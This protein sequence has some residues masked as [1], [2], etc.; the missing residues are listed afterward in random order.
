MNPNDHSACRHRAS[1]KVQSSPHSFFLPAVV[2]SLLF[3]VHAGAQDTSGRTEY[4]NPNA[5]STSS[6][7]RPSASKPAAATPARTSAVA[8]PAATRVAPAP[9]LAKHEDVNDISRFIAGLPPEHDAQL[10]VLAKDPEW[11]AYAASINAH[12][13]R[14][15]YIKLS[16]IRL[17]SPQELAGRHIN[18]VFYPFS[19]PD[20][21]Y[22]QTFF[23]QASTYILCG[24]EPVGDIPSL[25]KLQPLANS[26]DWLQSSMKTLWD[27]GYFVTKDMSVQLRMSPMQGTLPILCVMLE[28]SGNRITSIASNASRAEIHF[29]PAS[30]GDKVLY[31]FSADL[32]NG[33]LGKGS[34]L[35][36][37]LKS[38]HPDTVYVKSAS[39]LMHEDEFSAIRNFL[40]TQCR[41]IVQDDSGI[42]LRDFDLRRW[43]LKLYGTY[44]APLDIFAKYNQPDMAALYAKT[45][46]APLTFGAGYHWNF[47]EA[48][49]IVATAKSPSAAPAAVQTA[50]VSHTH[51]RAGA[52]KASA[53]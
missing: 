27:A 34:S 41:T 14:F 33:G 49:L 45:P 16:Q 31:Y 2:L 40:L 38:M 46:G 52:D 48:N 37:F 11:I 22:A 36:A 7:G 32:S 24:L 8:T 42:P 23:P 47:K 30:G 13:P 10:G 21:I 35:L 39:Y 5:A 26:L 44:T 17:W 9:V 43:N 12:W 51:Q 53:K 1:R 18:T 6:P 28:R 50:T 25:Q 20:F 29:V 3:T 15:D 4:Y 19:G